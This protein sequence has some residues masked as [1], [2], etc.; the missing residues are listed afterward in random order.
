MQEDNELIRRY[1]AGDHKAFD[2]IHKRYHDAVFRIAC[3][4]CGSPR[5]ADDIVQEVM[6]ALAKNL[7]A[8]KFNSRFFTYLYAITRNT[9]C[10][11]I[12]QEIRQ[13]IPQ[14]P[15]REYAVSDPTEITALNSAL[16]RL[17][18]KYRLPLLLK[19]Y[20]NMSYEEIAETVKINTGTVK[21]RIFYA[22]EKLASLLKEAGCRL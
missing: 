14:P 2:E 1:L 21:S 3:M 6:T 22:R 17:P 9:A 12:R 4:I 13:K 16:D 19:E 20:E 15:G 5:H 18:E 10:K 7:S 8:F 11:Y